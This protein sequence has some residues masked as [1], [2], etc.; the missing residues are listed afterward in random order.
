MIQ[1]ILTVFVLLSF[2]VYGN[3]NIPKFNSLAEEAAYKNKQEKLKSANNQKEEKVL[4]KEEFFKHYDEL[5]IDSENMLKKYAIKNEDS[6]EAIDNKYKNREQLFKERVLDIEKLKIKNIELQDY[7]YSSYRNSKEFAQRYPLSKLTQLEKPYLTYILGFG[8]YDNINSLNQYER[9][10]RAAYSSFSERQKDIVKQKEREREK[11]KEKKEKNLQVLKIEQERNK[12]KSAC[13]KWLK[14]AHKEVYSLGV[15]E[16]IIN[17]KNGGTFTISKVEKNTFLIGF[18]T[19]WNTYETKYVQKS[20]FI[21]Y[22]ALQSAP[23]KYC[24]K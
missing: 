17:L 11:E 10:L 22:R 23:S 16:K 7:K 14:N 1:K 13:E 18:N 2:Y 20:D 8:S 9:Y 19:L 21:P 15:G 4:S 3:E 12:V 5:Y 6:L 24:Y